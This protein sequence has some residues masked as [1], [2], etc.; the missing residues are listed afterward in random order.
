[1]KITFLIGNGFDIAIASKL[2]IRKTGYKDIYNRNEFYGFNKIELGNNKLVKSIFDDKDYL[3]SDFEDVLVSYF[4]NLN[5][6]SEVL[7]FYRDKDN[8]CGYIY[9]YLKNFYEENVKKKNFINICI[10]EFSNSILRFIDRMDANDKIKVKDYLFSKDDGSE[11]IFV[12]FINFNGTNTLKLLVDELKSKNLNMMVGNK[13]FK[14]VLEDVNYVHSKLD[15]KTQNYHEYAFGTT[16][17]NNIKN[18]LS[19][20]KSICNLLN[21][22]NYNF[23]EWVK[24][25]DLFITHGLSFGN[26]DEYYWGEVIKKIY[27]DSMLIDFPFVKK[28]SKMS[29]ENIDRIKKQIFKKIAKY[30]DNSKVDQNII[31]SICSEF[32]NQQDSAGI[33]SF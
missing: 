14:L 7:D 30:D 19:L 22:T 16:S 10:D 13:T 18:Q 21:K 28:E 26:S 11:T 25:T 9:E 20:P 29:E 4:N 32:K 27:K 15:G 12:N 1:M 8:F 3:R 6:E 23:K 33:F 31:I 5:D 2:N 24:D 17:E